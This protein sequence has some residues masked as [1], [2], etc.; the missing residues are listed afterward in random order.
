MSKG[1]ATRDAH[2]PGLIVLYLTEVWE[3]F[4]F[5]GMKALLVLYLNDGVLQEQRLSYVMGSQV[6]VACFGQPA[7]APEVQALASTLNELYAGVAYL[8]PLAGGLLADAFL[9]SRATLLLGGV[10]MALGHACMALERTFLLGLLFLVLG[11]G[12]FKPTITAMLSRLYEP[13]GPASLRDRGFAIFYTGINVG[14]LLAPLVCGALQHNFG[15]DAGF[16]AAGVGMVIGLLTFLAGSPWLRIAAEGDAHEALLSSSSSGPAAN[17]AP[18]SQS[19]L[20]SMAALMGLCATV[21]PFWVPFE[22]LSNVLPLFFRERTERHVL[23]MSILAPWLQGVN[24]LVCVC[25][26]PVLTSLW[27]RQARRG[28][29]PAPTSKMAIGCLLQSGAWLLMAAGSVGVTA[30]AKAPLLLLLTVVFLLTLAQLYMSPIALAL[31]TRCCPA[32]A[33]ST[34]VGLWFL[35]GGVGGVLAGPVG[36]LYGTWTSPAFFSLLA[37]ISAF[38][39]LLISCVAPRLQRLAMAASVKSEQAKRLIS[40]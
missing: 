9:G 27:G 39:A 36:A 20:G 19:T 12:G 29:E 32:H 8:T 21:V 1:G 17:V 5:Y 16:G 7:D 15:Y 2:P 4:S 10:L 31:V 25:V 13:P 26:M 28:T 35:A 30:D 33:R 22:Q 18:T 23:G 37:A 38:G 40:V 6:V 24:P 34:A 3:R 11:N 14:A